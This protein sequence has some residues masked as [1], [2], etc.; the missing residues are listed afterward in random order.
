MSLERESLNIGSPGQEGREV[1]CG[2][3]PAE[4]RKAQTYSE[5]SSAKFVPG[6]SRTGKGEADAM[7]SLRIQV[8]R[9]G[10]VWGAVLLATTAHTFGQ[11]GNGSLTGIVRDSTGATVPGAEITL[12]EPSTQTKY[13]T[14]TN[15]QGVYSFPVVQVGSYTMTGS[16]SGFKR[17]IQQGI[18]VSIGN[19]ATIDVVL[20]VGQVAQTVEIHADASQLQT[21]TSDIGTTVTPVL[22]EALPLQ[23]GSV[24]RSSI[25]FVD[26]TPGFE[27]DASGNPGLQTGFK[28]NGSPTG[29]TDV[30]LDGASVLFASPNLQTNY[31]MS[32]DAVTEFKV[33]TNTFSAEYGRV[34]GGVVNLAS[35]SGS[36]SLHGGVYEL[37]KN[38]VFDANSWMNNHQNISRP[39]DT[40]S[41]FGAFAGGPVRLP[42]IYNGRDKT[43]WYFA[44]EGF[45]YKSGGQGLDSVA[46]PAMWQNGDFSSVL[47]TQIIHGVTYAGRQ[48]YDYTT[49]TGPNAGN[50]CQPFPNNQIPTS[51]LDPM[52]KAA[53]QAHVVQTAS[54]NTS[55]PYQNQPTHTLNIN[56][57]N[58]WSAK[59]DQNLGSRQKIS[60]SY[61]VAKMPI[62]D[63]NL[64]YGPLW[65]NDFGGTNS[66]YVR[67]GHEYTIKPNL[68]N[69]LNF[70]YTRRYRAETSP[71]TIGTWASKLNWHGAL[72]DKV[73]PWLAAEYG[74]A[75]D[76]PFAPSNDSEFADNTYQFDEALFWSHGRHNLKFGAEHRRQ[77]FNVRY[78]SNADGQFYYNNVLTS[79]GN[80]VSGNP[81]DPN[82]GLGLAS[83]FL[84]ALSNGDIPAGQGDG[85]RANYYAVFAQDDWKVSNRLTVNLGLRYEIPEPVYE[86]L[87]RTSQVNPTLQNPGADNLPGAMQYQGTGIG[88]DGRRSPQDTFY[89]SF[90][91]RVGFAYQ[92]DPQTTVRIGYG[93]YYE[94]LKVSNFANSDSAGFFA[95]NYNFPTQGNL[96]TP[97]A[98]LSQLSAYRIRRLQPSPIYQF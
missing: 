28:L 79:A 26:L 9:S 53:I 46:L 4:H 35:K 70:G 73:V 82:S 88:R 91:P 96:E 58:N 80:D 81:I 65:T 5:H 83:F 63:E 22:L 87:D 17:Y 23:F 72:N 41:D 86:T 98:I 47:N 42:W 57:D 89:K 3:A 27:G 93:I 61:W 50:P 66:H 39:Y 16:V 18:T 49:C 10:I 52:S 32:T 94:A 12:T 62:L 6:R 13:H 25:Q 64:T 7:G 40:Q 90:G 20:Q 33:Q 34:G 92:I 14:T 48:I 24:L 74:T 45:R 51:R 31:A 71:N 2:T 55:Q 8:L 84:G 11:S 30:L 78:F 1:V 95:L 69:H 54:A 15:T 75:G 36:N 59:I 60:G 76:D 43:F 19:T 67:L 68:L 85:M 97:A 21:Q 44:Y 29:A 77:E 37:L 56:N 38:N